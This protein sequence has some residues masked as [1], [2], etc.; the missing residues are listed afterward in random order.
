MSRRDSDALAAQ[1]AD[2]P[3]I[4]SDEGE[5]VFTEPWQAQAFALAVQLSAEGY[6]TWKE[7]AAVLA[8]ELKAAVERGE[9]DDGSH[10]Y[11]YWLATLERLAIAKGL[12]DSTAMAKCKE[13]WTNAYRHSPHGQ[14]V[15]LPST[16]VDASD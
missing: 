13:A 1:L 12:A 14:P 2:L 11:N 16:A 3:R 7:W 15:T 4:P 9:T 8:D 10:Y 5:P 6:F